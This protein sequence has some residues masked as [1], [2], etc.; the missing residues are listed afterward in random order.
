MRSALGRAVCAKRSRLPAFP[1][2]NPCYPPSGAGAG[3]STLLRMDIHA[4][5]KPIHSVRE[6][7]LHIA[8]VTLG[9]LIAL[10]LEG[11]RESIHDH[12]LVRETR[13]NLRDEIEL[14]HEHMKDEFDRVTA[15]HNRLAAL[16]GR[17]P[18]LGAHNPAEVL[19]E[20]NKVNN[21]YYFFAANAWQAALS[22][23]ALA[24]M[25]TE[26][27][28]AYAWAAEGTRIYVGAQMATLQAQREAIAWWQAHPKPS[29]EQLPDG[30]E[31]IVLW[32]Q[33]EEALFSIAPQNQ[34]GYENALKFARQ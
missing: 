5:E 20:L 17:L 30:V 10:G 12:R 19:S 11:I 7:L 13:A 14:G 28:S 34:R 22:S 6:F 1:A 21:P 8:V 15:G 18:G 25:S 4:P 33:E 31:R 26:E 23:G 16:V 3:S 32:D 29:A 2:G 24:H 27:L 9:I